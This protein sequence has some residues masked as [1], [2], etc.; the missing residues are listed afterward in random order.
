MGELLNSAREVLFGYAERGVFD[1]CV[2]TSQRGRHAF[3]FRWLLG[4]QFCCVV[5]EA[6]GAL[7]LKDLL[8]EVPTRGF[9]DQ[10]LRRF[11]KARGAADLPEHRRL[12]SSVGVLMYR[13]RQA[14][15]SLGLR[16]ASGPSARATKRLLGVCN[17][18]F[19][20]LH[21]YHID[22]LHREFGLPEE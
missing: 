20:H 5:D 9:M 19:A 14:Q 21:L 18:L 4:H 8:P 16:L 15:V 17:D 13:N 6:R 10:D 7:T 22:Y 12:D 11:I 2:E 3:R 1:G